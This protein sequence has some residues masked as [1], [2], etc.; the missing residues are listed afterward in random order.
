M[1]VVY[2]SL[3]IGIINIVVASCVLAQHVKDDYDYLSVSVSE[4]DPSI[5]TTV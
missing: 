4:D 1:L 3:I 2:V 5:I